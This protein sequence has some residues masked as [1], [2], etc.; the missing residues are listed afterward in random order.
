MSN[1]IADDEKLAKIEEFRNWLQNNDVS[2]VEK[3]NG[4]FQIFNAK[5]KLIFQVWATTGRMN[6]QTS[7]SVVNGLSQI[8]KYLD[9]Y[10][11]DQQEGEV[12][13]TKHKLPDFLSDAR[14]EFIIRVGK[15]REKPANMQFTDCILVVVVETLT[16]AKETIVNYQDIEAKV[17]YYMD[18]YDDS[19]RLK[20]NKHIRILGTMIV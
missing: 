2:F 6:V 10:F 9:N 3:V 8:E 16:G 1:P 5:G 11:A 14:R 18:A 20:T 17:D 15:E 7:G 4:H 13:D 12:F 19:F